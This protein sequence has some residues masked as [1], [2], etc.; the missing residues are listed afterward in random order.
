MQKMIIGK[1]TG[2]STTRPLHFLLGA[3]AVFVTPQAAATGISDER[4]DR[5]ESRIV[6]LQDKIGELEQQT[7]PTGLNT[8][9][10]GAPQFEDKEKGW[11]FKPR[12][13]I[14]FDSAYAERPDNADANIRHP[15][16]STLIR[17]A[18]LGVE[19]TLAGG[20]GYK[21]EADFANSKVGFADVVLS[22]TPLDS[23]FSVTLGNQESL[24]GMEQMSSSRWSSFIER[25]QVNDAFTN[26]RRLG[27]SAGYTSEY[28]RF[29][30]NAGIF[31]AHSIDV[32]LD[33]DGWIGALR[34]T[35]TPT[36]G[37]GL[38][39]FGFN[40]QY[41]QFQSNNG[42]V[43]SSSSGAPSTNQFARYRARPFLRT[44][45]Q[46]LVDTGDIAAKG[47]TILGMEV[48]GLFG[49]LHVG[50]EAQFAK[51]RTY[52]PGDIRTGLDA[53]AGDI[54]VTPDSNP[55]FWG[56]HVELGYFLTGETRG[57][58]NGL[59][60]RTRVL[61]PVGDGGWGALQLIGRVDHL[62][63][64]N[65]SLRAARTNNFATGTSILAP[66][67]SRDARGG[68]QT[69]YLFGLTWI[70]VDHVRF[71][72]NYIHTDVRGGPL[73]KSANLGSSSRHYSIDAI[74]MR[75]QLHF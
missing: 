30:I 22:Y 28:N 44:T 62:D 67:A 68:S 32:S 39:H 13:R 49:P 35:Y 50:G 64:N 14:M 6:D 15:G 45:N 73:A 17:R 63:L 59:W 69:G 38:I 16:V 72:L 51:V 65:S 7:A 26:S 47:D 48:Y 71:L 27:V 8:T 12:G 41:R 75:A 5:L 29:R 52:R 46:R 58:K 10:K 54:G 40:Y 56:G 24:N 61:R 42:A 74:A 25:A 21:M 43:T 33:N 66:Q 31:A 18:R 9:W 2:T 4:A 70:P 55:S 36:I 34:A 3:A 37:H 11:S 20:F 57:Y 53:F 1:R 19:G 60:D 23:P